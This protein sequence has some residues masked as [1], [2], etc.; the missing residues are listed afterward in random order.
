MRILSTMSCKAVSSLIAR[1]RCVLPL[2]EVI[3]V[4]LLTGKV[5]KLSR[6]SS[7][8][9]ATRDYCSFD[10]EISEPTKYTYDVD[11]LDTKSNIVI[12]RLSRA[13]LRD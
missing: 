2:V 4:A 5:V 12:L 13:I 7:S 3:E 9:V 1:S 11:P 8:T 6:N 10:M